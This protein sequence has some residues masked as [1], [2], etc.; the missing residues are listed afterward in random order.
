LLVIEVKS[1]VPDMQAMLHGIDRKGRLAREIARD[2]GWVASS[3]TRLLVLPDDRTARRR[4][5]AHAATLG[6]A[7]PARTLAIRRW[8]REPAGPA[9]GHGIMFVT[10]ARHAGIRHRR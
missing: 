3:V 5:E 9:P 8:I 10:D 7:L 1:V 6:V 4:V 2:R